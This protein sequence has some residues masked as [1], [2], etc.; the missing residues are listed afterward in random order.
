MRT[1]TLPKWLTAGH[2]GHT[3]PRDRSRLR[4]G[5]PRVLSM[6]NVQQF[7]IGFLTALG[8]DAQNIVFSS[9]TSE[10]Q[11]RRFGKGRATVDCC[12]PVKCVTGH[13]GELVFG[14]K[15]GIDIL[16]HPMHYSV[17]SI[18]KGNVMN[19]LTCPRDMAAAEN[20]RAGFQKERDLFREHNIT[21]L[22]PFVTLA[23]PRLVPGQLQSALGD[24]LGLTEQETR[25]AVSAGYR[26]LDAFNREMRAESRKIIE[27]CAANGKPCA[28]VLARPYH[29]DPGIGHEVESHLQQH[30]IPILWTHYLPIDDD[31]MEWLFGAE[32][33]RGEIRNAF[34]I[35]D[36]WESSYSNSTNELIWSAK[37]AARLPWVT[38]VLRLSSY[39]CGMDQP[40]YTPTQRI[41]E[42]GG[43]LYFRFGDLDETKPAGSVKIRIETIV[44]YVS[45]YS[46]RIIR[47]KLGAL[48]PCVP[49]GGGGLARERTEHESTA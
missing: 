35:A 41:V 15:R 33:A 44:H 10:E 11:F 38:C 21:Y 14:Q 47:A 23:D 12:F 31:I 37:V 42:A 43:T 7:W 26:A 27:W 49:L 16:L 34:D 28:L 36:V 40:T 17:P 20:I 30:G 6:W 39:E 18:L 3:P 4:I 13:Y 46:D 29:M 5:I 19:T 2:F 45:Q 24:A 1:P 32:I 25:N 22:T 8:I 48:P 9:D